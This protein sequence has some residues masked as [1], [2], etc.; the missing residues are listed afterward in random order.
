MIS[1]LVVECGAYFADLIEKY[2]TQAAPKLDTKTIHL[3]SDKIRELEFGPQLVIGNIVE[4]TFGG[5]EAAR[6]VIA[7]V[8]G[9]AR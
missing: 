7:L 9:K 5:H 3:I 4:N 6:Y 8:T 2:G 1:E